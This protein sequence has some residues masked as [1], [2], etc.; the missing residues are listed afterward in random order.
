VVTGSLHQIQEVSGG[1]GYMS[2]NSLVLH[3]GLG[4]ATV[5]DSVTIR[6]PSG[7]V[8]TYYAMAADQKCTLTELDIVAVDDV[9]TP[10]PRFQFS[11]PKPNPSLDAAGL[12]FALPRAGWARL[13]IYDVSGRLVTTL[14]DR[15]LQAGWH[16]I[17]W[18]RTDSRGA[19]VASGVYMAKL[20]A[21]GEVRTQKLVL[22]R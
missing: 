13:A 17:I 3:F 4:A 12:R 1:S 19:R 2:Q 5:A 21:L 18:A 6:W 14:V 10:A 20:E 15:T 16:P 7:V 8:E 22:L 11:T 9:S